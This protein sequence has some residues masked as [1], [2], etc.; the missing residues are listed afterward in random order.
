MKTKVFHIVRIGI[1][2]V[3]I[4]SGFAKVLDTQAFV[5]LVRQYVPGDLAIV[6]V[7]IPPV[8]AILGLGLLLGYQ[9]REIAGTLAWLTLFFTIVYSYGLVSKGITDCACFGM[10]KKLQLPPWAVYVRNVLLLAGSFW[11]ANTYPSCQEAAPIDRIRGAIAILFGAAAFLLA[12]MSLDG[13]V[14]RNRVDNPQWLGLPRSRTPFST[15]SLSA[16]STYVLY[17]Y[18]PDCLLCKD[19][20][21]NA[22]SW[23]EAGLVDAVI[24]LT[25]RS[26]ARASDSLF[27]PSYGRYFDDLDLLTDQ[28]MAA[29]VSHVPTLVVIEDDTV[30]YIRTGRLANGFRIRPIQKHKREP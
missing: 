24:A 27:R 18:R 9:S 26:H 22:A 17:L 11:V 28:Q 6:A 23:R 8:E 30:T 3:F 25:A 12:G 2:L 7:I 5:A 4:T 19:V 10:A 15:L 13:P 20:A 14:R 21:A 16:D 29:A 1:A